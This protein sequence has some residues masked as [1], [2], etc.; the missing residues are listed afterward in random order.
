M[1][2]KILQTPEGRKTFKR[3]MVDALRAG[4]PTSKVTA[5]EKV[6][7]KTQANLQKKKKKKVQPSGM[8]MSGTGSKS[9][10]RSL[11]DPM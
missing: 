11:I 8:I 9:K 7:T 1:F 5:K 4:T 2:G 6:A 3:V 10:I